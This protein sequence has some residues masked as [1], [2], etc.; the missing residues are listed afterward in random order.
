MNDSHIPDTFPQAYQS[1]T[2]PSVAI[3]SCWKKHFRTQRS[4]RD[5]FMQTTPLLISK[6]KLFSGSHVTS[7]PMIGDIL[8]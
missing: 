7:S 1:L 2:I 3:F 4:N 5:A 8:Q 6:S